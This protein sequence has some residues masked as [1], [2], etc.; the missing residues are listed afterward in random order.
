MLA[1]VFGILSALLMLAF[2]SSRGGS[3]EKS[4]SGGGP[5]ESVVVATRNVSV[6]E[7]I[8][9][10]M[11]EPRSLPVAVLLTGYIAGKDSASIVGKV[12]TAPIFQGEQVLTGKVT[13]YEGQNTIG[14]KVPPGMR[15]LSLTVPHE[16]WIAAGLPQPGDHVDVIGITTL[17]RVDPLTGQE[18]PDVVSGYVAQDVEILAVAQSL[19]KTIPN[20]DAQKAASNGSGGATGS[21]GSTASTDTTAG[22]LQTSVNPDSKVDTYEKAISITLALTPETA[23]KLALLDAAKDDVAQFRIVPRQKGDTEPLSGTII[24]TWDDIFP[25]KKK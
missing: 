24:W 21:N 12:A 20:T 4:V 5:A 25:A 13:S 19:V 2:L 18:K 17:K 23:A 15:A 11:L 14:W 6:G 1:A 10:D 16:A 22:Q 3:D 7:K 8:T 9:A